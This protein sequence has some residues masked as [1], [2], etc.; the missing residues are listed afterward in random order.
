MVP[1]NG[2]TL[3]VQRLD[4]TGPAPGGRTGPTPAAVLI[5]G[6]AS[7]TMASWYFTMAEPLARAGFPTVLYDL[8]GHGR[9]ERPATGYALDDLVDDLA[10]LL[11]GLDV[12]GPLLLLGNS[13]G[14]TIAFGY[15][16]RHPDRVA[17]IVAVESAP[18]T[19]EW[20]RRVRVRL[21]RVAARLPQ[22]GA[23]AE[24]GVAR[25][26]VAARRAAETGRMLAD[27]T[28]AQELP[29]SRL[30]TTEALAA[31]GCPVLCV[32]GGASA[33]R[34]LAPAVRGLLPQARVV[35]LPEQRH[36]VLIDRPEEVRRLVFAWLAEEC[37]LDVARSTTA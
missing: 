2:I 20:M 33:V 32:Y 9:S 23:L 31:I 10:A 7:D 35:V 37:S 12:T 13:F 29:A 16:A 28:L 8:R 25:G 1:A 26:R 3:H 14:A 30:P 5:H 36:T 4:P 27:T 6:M 24:I 21:D 22:R 11:A 17:G 19:P 18:P 15:A 34:E